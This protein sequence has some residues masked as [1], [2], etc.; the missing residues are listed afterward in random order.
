VLVLMFTINAI[1]GIDNLLP[2]N[3]EIASWRWRLLDCWVLS[4]I[5]A[6]A[7]C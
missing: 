3:G 5:K 2:N 4:G 6:P 7:T 1:E